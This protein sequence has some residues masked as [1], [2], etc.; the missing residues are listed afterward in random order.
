MK[1]GGP[2]RGAEACSDPSLRMTDEERLRY[3]R[4]G[5]LLREATFG[6]DE[7]AELRVVVEEVVAAVKDRAA[8][9][10]AGPEIQLADGHRLQLSSR[11]AIQWEWDDGSQEIRLV[12]PC[13]HLHSTIATL[14]RDPRFVEPMRD[15]LGCEDVALFTTKLNLKRPGEG[16]EFPHHQDYPYWY[17]RI[18]EQARDVATAILFLDDADAANGGL[19]VLPGSHRRGPAPRDPKDPTRFLADPSKLERSTEVAV[20]APAG[21]VLFF[22]PLLVHRSEANR[23][24][25]PRRALL[26]SY[27]P[28]GRVR[29]HEAP[30]HP[31]WVERLP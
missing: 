24:E 15:A 13:D 4:D 26:P 19:R 23:S 6:R 17:V 18:E 9:P 2:Q 28:A 31:G 10:G 20:A 30:L 7:L 5:Y 12:E 25:R 29:W 21:S 1:R 8:R 14:F 16:S 22:G 27:Q 3:E 11:A